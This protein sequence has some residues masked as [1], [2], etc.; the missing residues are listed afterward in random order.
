METVVDNTLPNNY[1]NVSE[2][3]HTHTHI[4]DYNKTVAGAL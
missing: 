4:K 2:H 1:N 3:T